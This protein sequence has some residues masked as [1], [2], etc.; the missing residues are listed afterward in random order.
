ML[1]RIEGKWWLSC[2]IIVFVIVRSFIEPFKS[3][4]LLAMVAALIIGIVTAVL[5]AIIPKSTQ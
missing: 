2:G 3:N 1:K 5:M 4:V